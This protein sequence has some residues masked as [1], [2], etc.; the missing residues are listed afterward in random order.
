MLAVPCQ[1]AGHR[2]RFTLIELLVVIAII[3]LLAS[4]LLPA[5]ASSREAARSTICLNNL[6]QV[7]AGNFL[8]ASD[9]DEFLVPAR[10]SLA[11]PCSYTVSDARN[12]WWYR[13]SLTNRYVDAK[14]LICPTDEYRTDWA[15][16]NSNVTYSRFPISF[17]YA[18]SV[19]DYYYGCY[20]LGGAAA[21]NWFG[22]RRTT[23]FAG[24]TSAADPSRAFVLFDWDSPAI[25]NPGSSTV[26]ASNVKVMGDWRKGNTNFSARHKGGRDSHASASFTTPLKPYI[27][28]LG[29]GN[30][31]FVDGHAEGIAAP[32]CVADFGDLKSFTKRYDYAGYGFN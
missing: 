22:P 9:N 11:A 6:K 19:G 15:E 27:P 17:G 10:I 20:N 7:M 28:L 32:F 2:M 29:N 21:P 14:S 13:L 30:F 16:K 25:V 24:S 12:Y 23:S 3:A 1:H 18:A 4:M 31:A 26:I 5:L 8:Y